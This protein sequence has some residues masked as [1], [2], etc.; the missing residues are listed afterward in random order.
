[1]MVRPSWVHLHCWTHH[2]RCWTNHH[3]WSPFP[4]CF[5]CCCWTCSPCYHSPCTVRR[6]AGY[7]YP[8]EDMRELWTWS[9]G[10]HLIPCLCWSSRCRPSWPGEEE[11]V[12]GRCSREG[13]EVVW[14][15][16]LNASEGRW[17]EHPI[18]PIM[19]LPVST[20]LARVEIIWHSVSPRLRHWNCPG[21]R[22]INL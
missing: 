17:A 6:G 14:E 2:L 5:C 12:R 1:M 4:R 16:R 18:Y 19:W 9:P 3:Y 21:F 20:F 13:E 8:C 10:L 11:V 22:F 15:L 7:P